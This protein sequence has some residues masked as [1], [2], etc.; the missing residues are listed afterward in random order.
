MEK[1]M[2]SFSDGQIIAQVFAVVFC[3]ADRFQLLLM[4]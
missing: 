4:V 2:F 3:K 1:T